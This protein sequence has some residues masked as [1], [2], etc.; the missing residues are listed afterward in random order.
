LTGRAAR[1]ARKVLLGPPTVSRSVGTRDN[2]RRFANEVAASAR[3]RGRPPRALVVGGARAG[4][5]FDALLESGVE[6]IETDVALGAR[7]GVVCD[8]HDLP[9]VDGGFDGVLCQAVLEHVIDP[10]RVVTEVRRVLGPGGVVYSEL[11]FMQQVHE[12]AYDFQRYTHLG[13]RRLFRNFDELASG[14]HNGPGM[15]LGWSVKYFLISFGGRSRVARG[16]LARVATLATFWLKYLDAFL[17]KTPGG[18]DAASG[19]YFLGRKR[20]NP[21]PDAEIVA[22]YRG[23]IRR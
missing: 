20:D 9:F 15:A 16:L 2:L 12:G 19:T 5:G 17:V 13:H 22:G 1:I 10:P 14:A 6:L 21:V 3:A 4:V 23:A 7:T 8:A 11:P 18:L